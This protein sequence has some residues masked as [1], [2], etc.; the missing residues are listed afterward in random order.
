MY[1]D[2]AKN[3]YLTLRESLCAGGAGERANI[4]EIVADKVAS[5]PLL[6]Q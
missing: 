5:K 3:D 4:S 1:A 2:A 6:I